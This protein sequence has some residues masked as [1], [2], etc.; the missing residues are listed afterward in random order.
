MNS[1]QTN[2]IPSQIPPTLTN[3]E[4]STSKNMTY[5]QKLLTDK[6]IKKDQAIIINALPDVQFKQYLIALGLIINPTTIISAS[7]I[8]QQRICV[9]FNSKENAQQL[10]KNHK[11][12]KIQNQ[13]TAIRSYITPTHRLLI[14]AMPVI[15]HQMII[16]KL[17]QYGAEP[18]SGMYNVSAGLHEA[19]FNHITSFRRFIFVKE[20][21]PILPESIDITYDNEIHKI[22]ITKDDTKCNKCLKYGHETQNCRSNIDNQN[23]MELDMPVSSNIMEQEEQDL[24]HKKRQ[25]SST[26][27]SQ[28]S[29]P[30]PVKK[31]Y[32]KP[33]NS[34]TMTEKEITLL[35]GPNTQPETTQILIT[36]TPISL[37]NTQNNTD[38]VTIDASSS[39]DDTE[40]EIT[41]EVQKINNTTPIIAAKSITYIEELKHPMELEPDKF[42]ITFEELEKLLKDSHGV[43]NI[44]QI[45][46]KYNPDN[47]IH[48][49][50]LLYDILNNPQTKAVFTRLKKKIKNARNTA[51]AISDV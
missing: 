37:T 1:N 5:S 42:I 27:T 32:E 35:Q 45:I 9:F 24:L 47:L 15:P 16:D 8:S 38:S 12:L 11:T 14:W 41:Q 46:Q 36:E 44:S 51:I 48:T 23:D 3:T 49:L 18:T 31:P 25:R 22:F 2:N 17:Q 7:R 33:E 20:N 28:D 43:K 4:P 19:G 29:D 39:E 13:T 26:N 21:H 10:I 40:S 6:I 50:D 30:E 34:Q